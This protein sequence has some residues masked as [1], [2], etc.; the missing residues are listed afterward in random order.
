[1]GATNAAVA[2][3]RSVSVS[4]ST[5]DGGDAWSFVIVSV[6]R[7]IVDAVV[8]VCG[9]VYVCGCV[10]ACRRRVEAKCTRAV[11]CRIRHP[12][13]ISGVTT[14]CASISLSLSVPLCS[15][16][17]RHF[18]KTPQFISTC[19]SGI[20]YWLHACRYASIVN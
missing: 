2:S 14:P 11:G 7:R 10:S 8:S 20:I 9:C 18:D 4:E 17:Y 12:A 13:R 3:P 16:H 5:V 19:M 1:M 6:S 15:V